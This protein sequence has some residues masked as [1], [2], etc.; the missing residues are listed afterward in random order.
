VGTTFSSWADYRPD[1]SGTVDPAT[2]A[3][4]GGTYA[5]VDPYGLWWSMASTSGSDF[6]E[7]VGPVPTVVSAQ[8][9]GAVV[10]AIRLSRLRVGPGVVAR[11]VGD[12]GLVGNLFTP[13]GEAGPGVVVLGGSGGG[14]M[15]CNNVAGL[16][17][18]RGFCALALA[19][20]GTPGTPATLTGIAVEY[21]GDAVAWML[22]QDEVLGPRVGL[23]GRSRGGELALL[24]GAEI[25][26]IGPVV[27]YAAGGVVW[28]G[29]DQASLGPDPGPAWTVAG[30]GHP[31]L[32]AEPAAVTSATRR[33]P[34]VL[35]RAFAQAMDDPVALR[36]ATIAVEA[37]RGP[38]LLITGGSDQL[39]PSHRLA[40]LTLQ[41]LC[42]REAITVPTAAWTTPAP[43]TGWG[44][45]PGC[46]PLHQ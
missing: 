42:G 37:I 30:A 43:A 46:L 3:P 22:R 27:A 12:H 36:R 14:L 38:V 7:G 25:S 31:Y 15:W 45:S 6:E 41:R 20:F 19:Y 1:A 29:L 44:P 18:S 34:A 2:V 32:L 10:A 5:G 8:V 13:A 39:W 4:D 16:L 11:A 40:E 9:D 35:A 23:I 21:V 17:A 26:D 24:A 33:Q 28:A